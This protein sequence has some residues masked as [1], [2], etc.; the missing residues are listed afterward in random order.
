[1]ANN[2]PLR[3]QVALVTGGSSGLGKAAA[4]ALA[5][6]GA[7]VAVIARSADDL[8]ATVSE[9]NGSGDGVRAV[10][11]PLDLADAA[12]VAQAVERVQENLGPVTI[13]VNAAGTDVPGSVED[14]DAAGW[15]RVMNV[16]LRAVFLLA[17]A[18][19][20]GMRR[21]G[22]GTIINIGSVAGRR[23]WANAGAYCASKFALTGLTQSLAAEGKDH[24]IRAC[25][26]YPGAMDTQWGAWTP[27][28]RDQ[29]TAAAAP[30]N[31][32]LPPG[33]VADLI[34][35]IAQSPREMVLNEV[36]VTPLLEKG[37]P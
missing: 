8:Q 18:V 30:A 25:L 11:V 34:A 17:K 24:G 26:L 35:W 37:W 31:E 7:D 9:I 15:D 27:D 20:P 32:S 12:E 28:D 23:G 36:T 13:L 1:M 19:F 21:A 10:A 33:H 22:G 4:L 3:G 2:K 6:A 29:E 5:G 16:N 14:I